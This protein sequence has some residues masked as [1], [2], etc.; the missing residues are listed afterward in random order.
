[1]NVDEKNFRLEVM[2]Q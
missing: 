1:M 2:A